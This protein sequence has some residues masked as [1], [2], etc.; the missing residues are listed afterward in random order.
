MD[1]RRKFDRVRLRCDVVLWNPAEGTV[2]QAETENI[3]CEGFYLLCETPYTPGD[4]LEATI[5]LFQC[6]SSDDPRALALQ[7][8]V[9]VMWTKPRSSGEYGVGCRIRSYMVVGR[10]HRERVQVSGA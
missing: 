6:D 8:R 7:C 10:R 3:S 2:V 4:E 9:E 5:Q 1:Q